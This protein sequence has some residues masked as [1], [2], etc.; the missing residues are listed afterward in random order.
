MR[1][2]LGPYTD[3]CGLHMETSSHSKRGQPVLYQNRL[4]EGSY[5]T[6]HTFGEKIKDFF[7]KNN[8][9]WGEY[10]KFAIIRNPWDRQVSFYN[11]LENMFPVA[12]FGFDEY[13]KKNSNTFD[14][15]LQ[16]YLRTAM[17]SVE[18]RE[19]DPVSDLKFKSR[20]PIMKRVTTKNEFGLGTGASLPPLKPAMFPPG[21][22]AELETTTQD[23]WFIDQ[24]GNDVV[25]TIM[26]FENLQNDFDDV[27]KTVGIPC[28]QFPHL[29]KVDHSSYEE[30]YNSE[31]KAIVAK[32]EEKMIKRFGYEFG[33]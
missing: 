18:E 21:I 3:L 31:R 25:D 26:R 2:I 29:N 16:Y 23:E 6:M 11:F 13:L 14:E 28:V 12:R 8:W 24:D 30:F 9:K 15:A 5:D 20:K 1:E 27:C 22:L 33:K 32:K 19:R 7:I 17:Q 4:E 10:Y